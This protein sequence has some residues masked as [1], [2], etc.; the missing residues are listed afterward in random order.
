MKND[1][2]CWRHQFARLWQKLD[3]SIGRPT[4][5][6]VGIFEHFA[7]PV[8]SQPG[9]KVAILGATPE[10]RS[11]LSKYSA[12]V[13]L[14]DASIEMIEAMTEMADCV[15][16]FERILIANWLD[17]PLPAESCDLILG[18]LVLS[19]LPFETH[20]SFL[21][22]I[23]NW[24]KPSGVLVTRIE[25]FKSCHRSYSCA[26][27]FSLVATKTDLQVAMTTLWDGAWLL[28]RQETRTIVVREFYDAV[29]T[30]LSMYPN[31]YVQRVLNR[32]GIV[33]PLD[34]IWCSYSETSLKKLLT[35]HF[36]ICNIDF[37]S[38]IDPVFRDYPRIFELRR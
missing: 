4:R 15:P 1:L 25:S 9:S 26:D 35:R 38:S 37:D 29:I 16:E 24:L 7:A 3:G 11:M 33:F 36:S 6:E 12:D 30:A 2:F 19:N 22:T 32:G 34:K 20:D 8:L 27:L 14:V 31:D 18:D 13:I 28:G 17:D 10:L 5:N 21:A 23:R